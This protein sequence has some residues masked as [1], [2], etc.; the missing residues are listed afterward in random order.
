MLGELDVGCEIE[1]RRTPDHKPDCI[2]EISDRN[3]LR[4]VRKTPLKTIACATVEF[5]WYRADSENWF[6]M[7]DAAEAA[8]KFMTDIGI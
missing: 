1:G 3:E 7:Y 8:N 2:S 4:F 6:A 5:R